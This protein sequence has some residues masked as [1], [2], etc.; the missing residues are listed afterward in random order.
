MTLQELQ[1]AFQ[2]LS[3]L[4]IAGGLIYTA[5]Q[6]KKQR[7]AQH[8]ANFAK[9]VE[10]QM[11]LREMRVSDPSLANVYRHDVEFAQNAD[12]VREYFFNLMQLSVFEIVWF[13]YTRGQVPEDYFKSWERRM[14]DIA[15]EQSF[16]LMWS[17]PSMKIM[18]D[19]FQNYMTALVN[20]VTPRNATT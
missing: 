13:G 12:Q 16:R 7:E 11:H 6:F 10:A 1:L 5:L 18:H 8:F 3:S 2:A 17:T 4:A 14:R 15:A 9:L 19:D 20:S